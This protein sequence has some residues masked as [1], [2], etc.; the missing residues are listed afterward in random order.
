MKES[1]DT[2]L[3]D[4]EFTYDGLGYD[5]VVPDDG[6]FGNNAGKKKS[7]WSFSYDLAK[8]LWNKAEPEDP[9]PGRTPQ[10][11]YG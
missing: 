6:Y 11:I 8:V 1:I 9:G 5:F 3:D 4:C 2:Y 10:A 7:A